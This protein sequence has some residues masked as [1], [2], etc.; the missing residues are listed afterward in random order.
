MFRLIERAIK[1]H[2]FYRIMSKHG[3]AILLSEEEYE[4]LVE[5]LDLLSVPGLV[6]SVRKARQDIRKGRT[7]SV[8]EVF[9]K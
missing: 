4:N 9:G 1:D 8:E 6:K 7:H 5:T 3:G 2:R